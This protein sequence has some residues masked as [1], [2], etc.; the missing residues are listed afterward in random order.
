MKLYRCDSRIFNLHFPSRLEQNCSAAT[1]SRQIFFKSMEEKSYSNM[2]KINFKVLA[3]YFLLLIPK[4][5][6][7]VLK[8]I[9]LMLVRNGQPC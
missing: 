9:K 4:I 1:Q 2:G 7:T 8:L 5:V 6:F 3:V